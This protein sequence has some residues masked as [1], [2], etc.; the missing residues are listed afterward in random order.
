[1]LVVFPS[2]TLILQDLNHS[3]K[4]PHFLDS[5]R[6]RRCSSSRA[7]LFPFSCSLGSQPFF[8][9]HQLIFLSCD[10]LILIPP[11]SGFVAA[12]GSDFP[13]LIVARSMLFMD[14]LSPRH[15][16]LIPWKPLRVWIFTASSFLLPV[17]EF[18]PV[19]LVSAWFFPS[20]CPVIT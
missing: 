19:Q 15:Q 1:V 9:H 18:L 8:L 6:P 12:G 11:R 10:F 14:F 2:V 4:A 13:A 20:V 17:A 16:V 7:A 3:S 5:G